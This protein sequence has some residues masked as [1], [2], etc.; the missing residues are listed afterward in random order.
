MVELR[1]LL[2]AREDSEGPAPLISE[3]SRPGMRMR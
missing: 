3:L 2:R 1:D